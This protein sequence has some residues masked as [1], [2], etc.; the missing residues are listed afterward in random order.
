MMARATARPLSQAVCTRGRPKA[1]PQRKTFP[2]RAKPSEPGAGVGVR[3]PTMI[4]S[5]ADVFPDG[6]RRW[7][8]NNLTGDDSIKGVFVRG[9]GTNNPAPPDLDGNGFATLGTT[10][11]WPTT[12]W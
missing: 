4:V 1:S 11:W 8:A 5:I 9:T 12:R 7:L 3:R 6:F 10:S 2:A